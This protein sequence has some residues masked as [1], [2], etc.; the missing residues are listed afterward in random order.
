MDSEKQNK[1][2]GQIAQLAATFIER[3]SNKTALITV[4]R[5]EV[6]E[7]GRS[8][9]IYISVLPESG[10]ESAINF[11]K[12]KRHDLRTVIKKGI[13]MINIPFI[14]VEIDKGE[15]ARHT[16]EAL[17]REGDKPASL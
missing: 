8:A 6:L 16:I 4:T 1:I 11:L 12:R 5:V 10:E 14:D 13:N 7:R 15:K 3:E 9:T 2:E 17:L